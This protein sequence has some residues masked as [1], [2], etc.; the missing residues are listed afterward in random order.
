MPRLGINLRTIEDNL[1]NLRSELRQIGKVFEVDLGTWESQKAFQ[2]K[3][4]VESGQALAALIVDHL[5]LSESL[6]LA[7]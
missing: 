4:M 2:Q 7:G 1:G 6:G 5:T 3:I